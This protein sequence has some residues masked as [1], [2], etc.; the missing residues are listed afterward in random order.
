M[1]TR[2]QYRELLIKKSATG[3]FPAIE[4]FSCRYRTPD[5]RACAVGILILDEKYTTDIEGNSAYA[6]CVRE[7][8]EY[9]EGVTQD[10]LEQVQGIHDRI[11]SDGEWNHEKFAVEVGQL[12]G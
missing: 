8:I 1:M 6:S 10:E 3:K 5:G 7:V 11:A 2:E 12:L 9:P 4:G